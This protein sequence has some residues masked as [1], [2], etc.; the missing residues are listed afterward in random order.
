MVKTALFSGGEFFKAQFFM[1]ITVFIFCCITIAFCF[2]PNIFVGVMLLL[3]WP[4]LLREVYLLINSAQVDISSDGLQLLITGA[5]GPVSV[6]L[7]NVDEI[8]PLLTIF[9]TCY[10]RNPKVSTDFIEINLKRTTVYGK[11]IHTLVKCEAI[12]YFSFKKEEIKYLNEL[13]ADS[14]KLRQKS[15]KLN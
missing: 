10:F 9:T 2:S 12:F 4:L 3:G 15:L 13:A 8:K 7:Y 6:D 5:K 11:R 14:R 1:A